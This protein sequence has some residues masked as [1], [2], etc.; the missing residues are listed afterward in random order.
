MSFIGLSCS[1]EGGILIHHSS[2]GMT[3][4]QLKYLIH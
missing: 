4:W 1:K 2:I 3:E